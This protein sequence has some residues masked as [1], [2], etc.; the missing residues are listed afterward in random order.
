MSDAKTKASY[1][2]ASAFYQ[3]IDVDLITLKTRI[4]AEPTAATPH[5]DSAWQQLHD[6]LL[7]PADS[8]KAIHKRDDIIP[9][10]ELRTMQQLVDAQA[11]ALLTRELSLKNA[12][13]AQ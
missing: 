12:K 8:M 7:A 6:N 4:D 13:P 9:A 5:L 2:S 1:R 10:S 11:G 3:K